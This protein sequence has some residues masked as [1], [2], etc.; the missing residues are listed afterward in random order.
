MKVIRVSPSDQ[1]KFIPL[2]KK[3]I[4][5]YTSETP[6][7][8][9]VEGSKQIPNCNGPQSTMCHYTSHISLG[10]FGICYDPFCMGLG[11]STK[12]RQKKQ[13]SK[14]NKAASLTLGSLL[15]SWSASAPWSASRRQ[16]C[17]SF[18]RKKMTQEERTLPGQQG[19]HG[20]RCKID[21]DS[22]LSP[23]QSH[24]KRKCVDK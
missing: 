24:A 18:R 23:V 9:M 14:K 19:E 8:S 4:A 11:D 22:A 15:P 21:A 7:T 16:S 3:G 12:S 20:E 2:H 13:H 5:P 6:C 1:A 17:Q 10:G